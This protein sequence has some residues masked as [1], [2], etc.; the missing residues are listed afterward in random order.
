RRGVGSRGR[1][2]DARRAAGARGADDDWA[3]RGAVRARGACARRG[4]WAVA[5]GGRAGHT[6]AAPVRP[7]RRGALRSLGRPRVPRR[8]PCRSMV[9][10]LWS[11]QRLPAWTGVT[12]V[13]GAH[14]G[15]AGR[16]TGAP[17]S[18]RG[19]GV[20]GTA[21]VPIREATRSNAKREASFAFLRVS[22]RIL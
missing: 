22:S 3:T 11:L 7:R 12:R 17:P 9:Q 20:A 18:R 21:V 16:G 4:Q 10:P 19:T 1:E 14:R 15:G 13:Y 2:P 6:D 8:R 5:P